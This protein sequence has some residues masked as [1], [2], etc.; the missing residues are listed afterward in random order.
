MIDPKKF[1]VLCAGDRIRI[2]KGQHP[3]KYYPEIIEDYKESCKLY[4]SI[5][6]G[7]PEYAAKILVKLLN[8][9]EDICV[10]FDDVESDFYKKMLEIDS[11]IGDKLLFLQTGNMCLPGNLAD[12]CFRGFE[13]PVHYWETLDYSK[14]VEMPLEEDIDIAGIWGETEFASVLREAFGLDATYK[15][16][17]LF[18]TVWGVDD[19][20][21]DDVY[22][23]VDSGDFMLKLIKLFVK[24]RELLR[25]FCIMNKTFL[26]F[27]AKEKP[28]EQPVEEKKYANMFIESLF[29]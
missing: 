22:Y 25:K 23:A 1:Y 11:D 6:D 7:T 18:Q 3:E 13:M 20:S 29:S 27:I 21:F 15:D 28:V 8:D 12:V 19:D 2:I 26:D 14:I 24:D 9:Q 10:I 4:I 16:Y 17:K 5:G